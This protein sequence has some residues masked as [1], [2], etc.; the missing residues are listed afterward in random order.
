MRLDQFMAIPIAIHAFEFGGSIQQ[1]EALV[2]KQLKEVNELRKPNVACFDIPAYFEM[3]APSSVCLDFDDLLAGKHSLANVRPAILGLL[4]EWGISD[5][6]QCKPWIQ[7]SPEW[8]VARRLARSSRDGK[9][10]WF[11][12]VCMNT[13]LCACL[14]LVS[15]GSNASN[16]GCGW[17][18]DL[19]ASADD[20][21]LTG[22]N[23]SVNASA[24][25]RTLVAER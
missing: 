9:I 1:A 24:S 2:M 18:D 17:L 14:F 12:P 4:R 23:N 13:L 3:N 20:R 15:A 10:Q 8:S 6:T 5:T 21:R 25:A 19:P 16:V 22:I 7:D 11:S